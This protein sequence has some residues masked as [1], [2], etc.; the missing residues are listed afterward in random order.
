MTTM[1]DT[2]AIQGLVKST[3]SGELLPPFILKTYERGKS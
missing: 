3:T 1:E 2:F